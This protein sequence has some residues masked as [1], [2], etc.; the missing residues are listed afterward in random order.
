MSK[1]NRR[2]ENVPAEAKRPEDHKRSTAEVMEEKEQRF[3]EVP[4][5]HL[6]VPFAQV[7]GIA[8]ARLNA[9]VARLKGVDSENVGPEALDAM[10]DII[11]Y[12]AY[13]FTL[14]KEEF[15]A[16]TCGPG[17]MGRAMELAFAYVGEL[18]KDV[19]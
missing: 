14:D 9:R 6:M 10:A 3:E 11:E 16:F 8:Q 13:N 17:G 1:N 15:L 2:W 4:G 5:H 18:G 19:A 12:I 7:D